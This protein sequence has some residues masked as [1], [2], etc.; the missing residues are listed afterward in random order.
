MTWHV[1]PV[2]DMVHVYPVDDLYEHAVET[3]L[4][5]CQPRYDEEDNIV[6]HNAFDEREAYETGTRTAH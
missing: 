3:R 1:Y 6:L 5:W 4:C 2:A